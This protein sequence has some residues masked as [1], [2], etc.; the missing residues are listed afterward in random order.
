ML[1]KITATYKSNTG[2]TLIEKLGMITF[3][4]GLLFFVAYKDFDIFID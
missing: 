2:F 3:L 1:S 4:S